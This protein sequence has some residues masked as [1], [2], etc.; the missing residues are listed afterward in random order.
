MPELKLVTE[1]NPTH[2]AGNYQ[3]LTIRLEIVVN[4]AQI[5]LTQYL[6][7]AQD[8]SMIIERVATS[9]PST[10]PF[11]SKITQPTDAEPLAVALDGWTRH[12]QS[13]GCVD[14]SI[15]KFRSTVETGAKDCG[16]TT[17][18]DITFEGV[19]EYLG[20]MKQERAGRARPTTM[21]CRRSRASQSG[22]SR[23][24]APKSTTWS[25]PKAPGTT[26]MRGRVLQLPRKPEASFEPPG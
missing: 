18:T 8:A 7:N 20:K 26:V 24:S 5:P 3:A 14:R 22:A 2:T 12:M 17:A 16:W 11:P 23:P 1:T 10:L 4:G 13:K 21:R 15:K 9:V 19:T 25:S 6:T